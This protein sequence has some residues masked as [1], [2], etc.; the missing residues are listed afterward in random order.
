MSLPRTTGTAI[1]LY[2]GRF[3]SINSRN[4][5]VAR[6]AFGTSIPTARFPGIGATMRT[7][8]AARRRAMLSCNATILLSLTPGAG[9]ISNIVT[10]GPF[11]IPVTSASILN[12]L[13]VSFKKFAASFVFSSIIQYF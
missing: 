2:S 6:F 9:K 12:S 11:L 13:S 1:F 8:L 5:T 7:E 10:T 4:V 3:C